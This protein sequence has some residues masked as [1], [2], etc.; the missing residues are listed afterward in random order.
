MNWKPRP[1][2]GSLKASDAMAYAIRAL[3]ARALTKHELTRKLSN[4]VQMKR[5]QIRLLVN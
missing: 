4:V 1:E 2:A 5:L 3:A